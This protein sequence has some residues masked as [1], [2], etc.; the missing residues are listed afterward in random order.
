M[1][2][3]FLSED[4]FNKLVEDLR[5]D[6]RLTYFKMVDVAPSARD[7]VEGQAGAVNDIVSAVPGYY[8][9]SPDIKGLRDSMHTFVDRMLDAVEKHNDQE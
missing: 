9:F 1:E 4:E 6:F 8:I 7:G 3:R 5:G 2:N